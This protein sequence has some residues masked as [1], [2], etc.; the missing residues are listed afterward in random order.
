MNEKCSRI[1]IAQ[2]KFR[3]GQHVRISRENEIFQGRRAELHQVVFEVF[4][5]SR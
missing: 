1:P 5:L 2:P 4:E 3:V